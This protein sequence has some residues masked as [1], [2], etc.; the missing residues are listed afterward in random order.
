[1][2]NKKLCQYLCLR[3]AVEKELFLTQNRGC[4]IYKSPNGLNIMKM[5]IRL[6][7]SIVLKFE[8]GWEIQFHQ[9]KQSLNTYRMACSSTTAS[10]LD[11]VRRTP[12]PPALMW[13]ASSQTP[14][15]KS[16]WANTQV[17]H[18]GCVLHQPQCDLQPDTKYLQSPG[19]RTL[20]LPLRMPSSLASLW[21]ASSQGWSTKSRWADTMEDPLYTAVR[22]DALSSSPSVTGL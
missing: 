10:H 2:E 14:S 1:M 17:H 19:E 7:S 3:F 13:P 11:S 6:Q 15:T 8:D 18:G 20:L 12:S 9:Q 4:K 16:R 22:R 21:P 5:W